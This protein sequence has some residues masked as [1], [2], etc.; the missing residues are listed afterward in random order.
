MEYISKNNSSFLFDGVQQHPKAL[1]EYPQYWIDEL[2]N[3]V[4]LGD[5]AWIL[6]KVL[7][8]ESIDLIYTA[9]APYLQYAESVG[10]GPI[11]DRFVGTQKNV[12]D[13][14]ERLAGILNK[15]AH[16]VLNERGH[17]WVDIPDVYEEDIESYLGIP[18]LFFIQM[19]YGDAHN[20]T[21]NNNR[22]YVHDKPMWYRTNPGLYQKSKRRFKWDLE[23][24]YR[25]TK[26]PLDDYYFNHRGNKHWITSLIPADINF[27]LAESGE[28]ASGYPEHLIEVA[29]E[30]CCPPDG[31]VLDPMGGTGTVGLVA[32]RLGRKFIMLDL[33]F[34]FCERMASR[35][36]EIGY[37]AI[38]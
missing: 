35:I 6:D 29:I 22:W 11:R 28:F 18:E 12:V 33:S 19:L 2:G 20:N 7:E 15:P 4:M 25:F 21:N 32:K 14:I 23:K 9:P 10:V 24:L 5:S 36:L 1:N 17:L 26:V 13:Y 38:V 27:T 30:T 31:V 3:K 34:P 8:K 16:R 37:K